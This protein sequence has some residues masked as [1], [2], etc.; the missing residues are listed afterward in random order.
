MKKFILTILFGMMLAFTASAQEQTKTQEQT[1]PKY[2]VIYSED[3]ADD[4][5]TYYA[6]Y[7]ID[8]AGKKIL[9]FDPEDPVVIE[10]PEYYI[11]GDI[12]SSKKEGNTET[13][14]FKQGQDPYEYKIVFTINPKLT[15]KDDLSSQILKS[16]VQGQEVDH[17]YKIYNYDQLPD[18]EK[19]NI[20]YTRKWREQ[21]A[22]KKSGGA[23]NSNSGGEDNQSVSGE[24]KP[25]DAINNAKDKVV[26]G[27]KNVFNKTKEV[28][29]K[30]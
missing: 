15:S 21:Q 22:A 23:T 5:K 27:A 18:E 16:Y 28:F 4:T 6:M 24:K 14:T 29:K 3:Y 11:P 19:E 30:K 10:S 25:G 9:N 20:E 1:K 7:F 26:G 12:K 8:R 13:I 2:E 17:V